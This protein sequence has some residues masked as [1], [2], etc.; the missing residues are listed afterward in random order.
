MNSNVSIK[1]V[2]IKSLSK[3][4]LQKR[5]QEIFDNSTSNKEALIAIYKLIF[6]DMDNIKKIEGYPVADKNLLPL[7]KKIKTTNFI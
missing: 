1:Q 7:F 5:I 2:E 6:P 3:N 4:Q